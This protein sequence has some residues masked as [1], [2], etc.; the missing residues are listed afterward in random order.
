MYVTAGVLAVSFLVG[1]A[2]LLLRYAFVALLPF[3]IALVFALMMEP[4]VRLLSRRLPRGL[5][6]LLTMTIFFA[7]AGL[8]LTVLVSHLITELGDLSGR[9]P[10]YI[11]EFQRMLTFLVTWIRDSYG[12]LPPQAVEYLENAITAVTTS[13]GESITIVISSFLGVL[14]SLPNAALILMVS[15]VATFFISRDRRVLG[16]FWVH[17]VPEPWGQHTL[18]FGREAFGAFLAY[19]RAQ[20]ILVMFTMFLATTGLYLLQVK[21][22][23]TLGLLI[24][25]FDVIPVLGPSAIFI[26]WIILAFV[27]GAKGFAVKLL[28][29]YAV[30]FIIRQLFEARIVAVSLGLHPLAVMVGMYAGLKLLGVTGLVF[31]PIVV[32]LIQAAYKAGLTSLKGRSL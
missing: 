3:I 30:V 9:L 32:I 10:W 1:L 21:Y 25:F 7:A 23:L 15:I 14:G 26:P 19:L 27:T 2:V 31:G 18:F 28:I 8:T 17:T 11:G 22:A 6:V 20:F 5:A 12:A 16:R 4:P 29:L 13:A 24:G